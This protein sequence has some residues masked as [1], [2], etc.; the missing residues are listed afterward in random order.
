MKRPQQIK[1]LED[2]LEQTKKLI[3]VVRE[4]AIKAAEA[5]S[6]AAA[7][8]LSAATETLTSTEDEFAELEDS[9]STTSTTTTEKPSKVPEAPPVF[10]LEDVA[11]VTSKYENVKA[12]LE[13]KLKLQLDLSPRDAPILTSIDIQAKAK[14]LSQ[15]AV[16]L[17]SRKSK[18]SRPSKSK[19]A[20]SKTKKSKTKSATAGAE[21]DSTKDEKRETPS[22]GGDFGDMPTI[23]LKPGASKEEIQDA[24]KE[25]EARQGKSSSHDEL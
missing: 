24:I 9:T 12:W 22:S 21:S 17:M 20:K 16:D 2:T 10:S 5:A 3:G 14:D 4:Q 25:A 7:E 19:S 11:A 1:L 6:S 15:M 8:A 13:E 23:K 18:P